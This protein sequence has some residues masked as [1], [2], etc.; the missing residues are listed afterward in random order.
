[1][2]WGMD[3]RI[4]V[5]NE[6]ITDKVVN[7]K[8]PLKWGALDEKGSFASCLNWQCLRA[9]IKCSQIV[10]T[11]HSAADFQVG[12]VLLTLQGRGTIGI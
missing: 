7:L 5:R 8:S 10:L 1:M 12:R 3:A 6:Q 9:Q 2:G 11:F 4:R